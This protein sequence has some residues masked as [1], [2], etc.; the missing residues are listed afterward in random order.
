MGMELVEVLTEAARRFAEQESVA[1]TADRIAELA[2]TVVPGVGSASVSLAR[3]GTLVTAAA[4]D[5]LAAAADDAQYGCGEG[6]CLRAVADDGVL[7]VDDL[8][9]DAR[10]PRF[11]ARAVELGLGSVLSCHLTGRGV[12]RSSLNLYARAPRAFDERSRAVAALY[13]THAGIAL[14]TALREEDLRTAVASRE[15]I[16]RAVGILMQRHHA[17]SEQAFRLLSTASQ[18][19]NIKVRRL[20]EIIAETGIDAGDTSELARQ[21]AKDAA[22]R[23]SELHDQLSS[24]TGRMRGSKPE[25]VSEANRRA[26]QAAARAADRLQRTMAAYL[27]AAEAHERAAL[28]HEKM[29]RSGTD[30]TDHLRQAEEHRQAAAAARQAVENGLTGS[31]GAGQAGA[32]SGRPER[33]TEGETPRTGT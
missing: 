12:A 1:A 15:A 29:A 9:G 5:E 16:S 28:L 27:S 13:A 33:T 31:A 4:T 6:P 8:A 21:A 19:L 18:K 17:T 24:Q 7:A 32:G 11:T 23:A 26:K 25:H 20:A 3:S 10:W 2:V 22:A 14:A 30:G